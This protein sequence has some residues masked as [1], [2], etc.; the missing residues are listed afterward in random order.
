MGLFCVFKLGSLI[1]FLY[2]CF[3]NVF[4]VRLYTK[5]LNNSLKLVELCNK[6]YI[7]PF[8]RRPSNC[9]TNE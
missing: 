5:I 4:V 8:R 9:V 1:F 2:K 6:N 3:V 7:S